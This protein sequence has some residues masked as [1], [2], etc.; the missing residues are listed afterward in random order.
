MLLRAKLSLKGLLLNHW[1]KTMNEKK[2]NKFNHMNC[3][4]FSFFFFCPWTLSSSVY[5]CE[6]E[7]EIRWTFKKVQC[8]PVAWALALRSGELGLKTL[9]DQIGQINARVFSLFLSQFLFC[10]VVSLIVFRWPWKA[11]I[12]S[13]QSSIFCIMYKLF[14]RGWQKFNKLERK[15]LFSLRSDHLCMWLCLRH[16][17][18]W[19]L[20]LLFVCL[21]L[22]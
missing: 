11:P 5:S 22:L 8:G 12:G 3:F 2:S 6:R 19:G 15:S 4:L 16:A 10:S 7:N 13:S 21:F 18:E 17:N 14:C 1:L 20:D 9:S